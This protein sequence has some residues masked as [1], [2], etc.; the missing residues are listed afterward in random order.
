MYILVI[1]PSLDPFICNVFDFLDY[2]HTIDTEY[3]SCLTCMT[4]PGIHTGIH[5]LI[6]TTVYETACKHA[7]PIF[8]LFQLKSSIDLGTS[9][10]LD[11]N[12]WENTLRRIEELNMQTKFS[13]SKVFSYIHRT[14]YTLLQCNFE[15]HCISSWNVCM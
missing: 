2:I 12:Q 15:H 14:G 7:V 1:W 13:P 11:N 8:G 9:D 3:N 4:S 10:M 6:Q 5:P